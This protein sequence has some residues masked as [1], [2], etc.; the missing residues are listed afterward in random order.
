MKTKLILCAMACASLFACKKNDT[1][2]TPTNLPTLKTVN[3]T[4]PG[5]SDSTKATVSYDANGRVNQFTQTTYPGPTISTLTTT[6]NAYGYL[7]ATS[8]SSPG[9]SA[10]S[11]ITNDGAGHY[12][13]N[14]TTYTFA[15]DSALFTY[16]GSRITQQLHY[17]N[18]GTG[19][20]ASSKNIYTYDANGNLL[21]DSTATSLDGGITW[22][23]SARSKFTYDSKINPLQL[24]HDFLV[25]NG[26]SSDN[27]VFI[28]PNNVLSRVDEDLT[29]PSTSTTNFVYTYNSLNEPVSVT[30]TTSPG[31]QMVTTT[32]GY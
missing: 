3:T 25:I 16:T 26:N 22:T 14:V 6:R 24:G 12:L 7:T 8:N 11:V 17:T 1:T 29:A 20:M 4:G 2:T 10:T 23:G 28:G 9:F 5:A 13:T 15:K 21:M 30:G 18:N 31:G 27:Q 19:Y 32:Y